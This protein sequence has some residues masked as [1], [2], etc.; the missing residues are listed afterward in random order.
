[1]KSK[2]KIIVF[3]M[4]IFIFHF[5][6]SDVAKKSEIE[7]NETEIAEYFGVYDPWEPLN[8][9]VYYFNYTF[10]KYIFLPVTDAYN[11]ITPTF[12][13]KRVKN[14]FR[15]VENISI[16]GNSLLQFKIKKAMRSI[17][18]FSI[19][20]TL[21]VGGLFDTASALGMPKPYEDFGLTLARYG[22]GEGPYLILPFLGPSN[23]RDAMGTGVNTIA[24]GML[25]PYEAVDLLDIDSPE[26]SAISAV[27][28]RRNTKFRYYGSGSP[29]EYEYLR[30]FYKK[31]R[32]LQSETGVQ[33]F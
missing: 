10:D 28:K 9:R 12:V 30:F 33:G 27:N 6:F 2:R 23:L 7:N 31:Y 24:L 1:M 5:S 14:F 13:Q 11:F 15:N 21:G 29:F 26:V 18:R 3:L 22:V 17:G 16:T 19:N 20:A 8:R 25:D 32:K 4:M